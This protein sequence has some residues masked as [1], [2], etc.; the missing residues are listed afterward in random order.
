[1]IILN[2]L[3]FGFFGMLGAELALGLCFAIRTV[4]RTGGIK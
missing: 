1:M 3:C 4:F 2:S